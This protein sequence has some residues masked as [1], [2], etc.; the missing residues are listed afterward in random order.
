MVAG[1]EGGDRLPG[2]R[3]VVH[4]VVSRAQ[5]VQEE[6]APLAG[7]WVSVSVRA[8]SLRRSALGCG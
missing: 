1:Q 4:P 2:R 7:S 3:V 8:K 6:E 5:L